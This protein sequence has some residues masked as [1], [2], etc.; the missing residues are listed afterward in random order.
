MAGPGSGK[1]TVLV[2][3]FRWLVARQGFRPDEILAITFTEKAAANM[4][5]RLVVNSD[6]AHREAFQTA[7]I[8]TI[9][10]FCVRLLREHAFEAGLRRREWWS[11]CG[12][13]KTQRTSRY[14]KSAVR[15]GLG[16]EGHVKAEIEASLFSSV[17]LRSPINRRNPKWKGHT[18]SRPPEGKQSP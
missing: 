2:E 14:S 11:S 8:S 16:V 1:T 10:A 12:Y 9:H 4:L 5:E 7:Q 18:R 3:R 6:P 17:K 13:Q 15:M